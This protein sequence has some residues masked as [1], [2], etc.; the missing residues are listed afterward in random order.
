M[1]GDHPLNPPYSPSLI[2]EGKD[3]RRQSG[4]GANRNILQLRFNLIADAILYNQGVVKIQISIIKYIVH[5]KNQ[6]NQMKLKIKLALIL[7]FLTFT[8]LAQ[9]Q[10]Q[11]GYWQAANL[12]LDFTC[13][14][15]ALTFNPKFQSLHATASIAD[16]IGNF[17]FYSNNDTI[18]NKY[19]NP[20]PG[21]EKIKKAASHYNGM[22]L[23]LPTPGNSSL[24]YLFTNNTDIYYNQYYHIVDAYKNDGAGEVITYN[25]LLHEQVFCPIRATYDKVN[26]RYW[27]LF[28]SFKDQL[29]HAKTLDENGI[30]DHSVGNKIGLPLSSIKY[31]GIK[32]SPSGNLLLAYYGDD[33]EL[34]Q[35][36]KNTGKINL[37]VKWTIDNK[38]PSRAEFSPD[39]NKIYLMFYTI[40]END[41]NGNWKEKFISQIDISVK[42]STS[43]KQS[44]IRV[45]DLITYI[46]NDALQLAIDGKI[47]FHFNSSFYR[48]EEPNNTFPHCNI[49]EFLKSPELN[50]T[51]AT[52]FPNMASSFNDFPPYRPKSK[53][54]AIPDT[55]LCS[56][57]V[58]SIG[59]QTLPNTSYNWSPSHEVDDYQVANPNYSKINRT[60]MP[61]ITDLYL[62][63]QQNNCLF[64]DTVK[65]TVNP[66]METGSIVGGKSVCPY[67]ERVIYQ[68]ENTLQRDVS[69]QI[70]GGN[71]VNEELNSITVNWLDTNPNALVSINTVSPWGRCNTKKQLPV[72]INVELDTETPRGNETVCYN[73]RNENHYE[74]TNTTGSVYTWTL[75]GGS[76]INGQGSNQVEVSWHSNGNKQIWVHE[77]S[78]TIDT[79]CYGSSD[80]LGV[81]VFTDSAQVVIHSASVNLDSTISVSGQA[82]GN[83]S[84]P[85]QLKKENEYRTFNDR[86]FQDTSLVYHDASVNPAEDSYYYQMKLN[87]TCLQAKES[88]QHRTMLLSSIKNEDDALIDLQWNHYEGW[89][90]GVEMYEI[91]RKVDDNDWE[92]FGESEKPGFIYE[93]GLAGFNHQFR[94]KAIEKDGANQ[95][96]SNP[97]GNQFEH[98][99]FIPNV[100]TPNLDEFNEYFEI[101][102]LT[103]VYPQNY[104]KV[105]NRW[106]KEILNFVDYKN[107]WNASTLNNG[108]YYYELFTLKNDQKFTGYFQVIR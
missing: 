102:R 21:S 26:N 63:A 107:D 53:F 8:S 56:G 57:E 35:F 22:T 6:F 20:V 14:E 87:S 13:P 9:H 70:M 97:A 50:Y 71:L 76:V 24:Y 38:F 72:K 62:T 101:K 19:S 78:Q 3:C 74:I 58:I 44:E 91:Y 104:L 31:V 84:L 105:Y 11:G 82:L 5:I 103:E 94:I 69:W 75:N 27:L 67:V 88:E 96:W 4:G 55:T 61:R 89:H 46:R 60:D 1:Y 33:F 47:Y 51:S 49:V 83:F 106:G 42:D 10:L 64:K 95:A 59:N 32:F 93:D 85:L 30:S 54:Q 100:F 17:L 73:L 36:D 29:L 7:I 98:K 66:D 77:F 37:L 92:F 40:D 52:S 12:G 18:F 65:I 43:I 81:N 39:E 28:T 16:S 25:H 15:P 90:E 68:I 79:I 45:F 99:L 86:F 2:K 41:V 34:Y 23:L 48:I 80:T 108:V